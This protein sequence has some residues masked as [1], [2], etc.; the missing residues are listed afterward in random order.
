MYFLDMTNTLPS[1]EDD[2]SQVIVQT[3]SGE[4]RNKTLTKNINTFE[5]GRGGG[6][7]VRDS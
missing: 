4:K 6:G 5:V 2:R 7:D 1:I 3:K